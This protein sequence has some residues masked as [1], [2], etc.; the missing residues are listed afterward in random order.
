MPIRKHN[1]VVSAELTVQPNNE[2]KLYC[3]MSDGTDISYIDD[4]KY[5]KFFSRFTNLE[6]IRWHNIKCL[7]YN[8]ENFR[9]GYEIYDCRNNLIV[10]NESVPDGKEF[11]GYI[12]K[13]IPENESNVFRLDIAFTINYIFQ[14]RINLSEKG[15]IED[16]INDYLEQ[17]EHVVRILKMDKL[18]VYIKF[19]DNFNSD[20]EDNDIIA[21]KIMPHEAIRQ[22]DSIYKQV[23]YEN[24]YR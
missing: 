22:L 20:N 8:Y 19:K 4:I 3:K 1:K 24:A 9:V 10:L 5:R 12:I 11:F 21:F 15:V 23:V 13:S 14:T 2:E 18:P 16:G 6:I 7:I 17:F